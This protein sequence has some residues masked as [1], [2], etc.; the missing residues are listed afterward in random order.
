MTPVLERW[1]VDCPFWIAEQDEFF[2]PVS[3]RPTPGRLGATVWALIA[4][5][6]TG[7]DLSVTATSAAEAIE[8]YLTC[9]DED[10]A[11]GGL[12][13][14]AGDVV[15]DPGCCVGLDE[16]RD[17]LQVLG[18]QVIDLGHDPNVLV[19]HR[20]PV[21]RLWQ[22][23]DQLLPAE[24]PGP[25]DQHIDIPRKAL[26]GLLREV[27]RDLVGFLAALHPWARTIVADLADPLTAAVDR[28][29]R[30]SE[31]LDI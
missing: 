2:L 8:A 24:L 14:T 20:G 28:R 13:I 15:I 1:S 17:W 7:E 21:L 27:H 31:P 30:I 16:W 5:S 10:F 25:G 3:R 18:G 4:R 23:K 22:D 11:P 26:P 9:D 6:I 19:E 12:R 29:L